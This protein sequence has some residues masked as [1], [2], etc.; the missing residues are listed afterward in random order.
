M[1][2]VELHE[3]IN[4]STN[5][6]VYRFLSRSMS[7]TDHSDGAR[8]LFLLGVESVRDG[9]TERFDTKEVKL[10]SGDMVIVEAVPITW[11]G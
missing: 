5:F 2:K 7:F 11:K 6:R 4:G 8:Y 1:I 10:R 9:I 3:H